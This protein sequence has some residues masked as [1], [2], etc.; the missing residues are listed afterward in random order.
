MVEFVCN[1][2]GLPA[3]LSK[4]HYALYSIP[5]RACVTTNYDNLLERLGPDWTA[6]L[7]TARSEGYVRAAAHG[8]FFLWK[9]NGDLRH[10]DTI[11]LCP[12]ELYQAARDHARIPQTL[13]GLFRSHSFLFVGVSPERLLEDLTKLEFPTSDPGSRPR[14]WLVSGVSGRAWGSAARELDQMYGVR[15]IPFRASE[16]DA[17]LPVW[18]GR[19]AAE[20]QSVLQTT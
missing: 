11:L 18:L 17:E 6:R 7:F 4:S 16:V 13:H 3:Q 5:F 9:L 12:S 14:H 2:Y 1:L 19:L 15:L 20:A 8:T 10:H